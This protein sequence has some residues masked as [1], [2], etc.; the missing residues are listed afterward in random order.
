MTKK[1][2]N[3]KTNKKNKLKLKLLE[4]DN[5]FD[6]IYYIDQFKECGKYRQ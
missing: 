4:K 5:N 1:N 2:T 3:K 6:G